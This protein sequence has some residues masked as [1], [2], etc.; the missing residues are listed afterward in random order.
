MRTTVFFVLI[1]SSRKASRR[2]HFGVRTSWKPPFYVNNS[3]AY[4]IDTG[5]KNTIMPSYSET[6]RSHFREVLPSGVKGLDRSRRSKANLS[7]EASEIIESFRFCSRN[8]NQL[9]FYL[10]SV[11]IARHFLYWNN[12]GSDISRYKD[13]R[14]EEFILR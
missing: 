4:L 12:F 7:H 5:P 3:C 2:R 14:S 11:S 9:V 6:K 1:V 8:T 10:F 13:A